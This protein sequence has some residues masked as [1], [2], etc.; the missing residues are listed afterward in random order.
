VAVTPLNSKALNA[1]CNLGAVLVLLSNP[2]GFQQIL[3]TSEEKC[4][5]PL[6]PEGLRS[7]HRPRI[8]ANDDE[9]E[10]ENA[11]MPEYFLRLPCFFLSCKAN[12]R[13]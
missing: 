3:S 7:C 6:S 4:T 12:A 5:D 11:I 2:S 9:E 8:A 10:K 13:V 1:G